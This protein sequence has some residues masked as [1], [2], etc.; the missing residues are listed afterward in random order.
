[1]QNAR[2]NFTENFSGSRLDKKAVRQYVL[3]EEKVE[4]IGKSLKH[5]PQKALTHSTQDLHFQ[6]ISK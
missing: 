4:K 3:T 2:K 1:L 6:I 5:S